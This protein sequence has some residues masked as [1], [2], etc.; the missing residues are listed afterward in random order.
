MSLGRAI[1]CILLPPLA[2]LD[3]GCGS[4]II[5]SVLTLLGWVPGIIGALIICKKDRPA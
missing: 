3:K 2:V 1:L 5:V 4:I